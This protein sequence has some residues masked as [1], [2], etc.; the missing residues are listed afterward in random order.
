MQF[1]IYLESKQLDMPNMNFYRVEPCIFIDAHADANSRV[2][3][4]ISRLKMLSDFNGKSI[5]LLTQY[6]YFTW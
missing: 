3:I 1:F 4:H 5:S 2:Y 6:L